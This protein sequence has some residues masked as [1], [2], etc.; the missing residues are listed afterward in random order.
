MTFG[1]KIASSLFQKAMT[2]IFSPIME[3][4]LI[5][6]NDILLFSL[7][8][9]SHRN[10]LERFHQI[11]QQYG[12]ILVEKKM[13]IATTEVDFLGMHLKY[14]QYVAQPHISQEL[15]NF[16]NSNLTRKLVQQFLGIVNYVSEFIPNLAQMTGPLNQ[17]LK[18]DSLQ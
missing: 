2:K 9:T 11:I 14:G 7:D 6:I 3:N 1:L 15:Y 17:L 13:T 12:I 5:Y 8:E 16:P 18:K 4:A 10:L